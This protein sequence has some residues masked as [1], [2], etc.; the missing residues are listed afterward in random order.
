MKNILLARRYASAS[1]QFLNENDYIA[2]LKQLEI[3]KKAIAD[4]LQIK[5]I[6]AS[7]IISKN[8]KI[9]FAQNIVE[10]LDNK[11]FWLQIITVLINKNRGNILDLFLEEFKKVLNEKLNQKYVQLILAHKQDNNTIELI[12]NEL[13]KVLKFKVVCDVEIDKK[14]IGGFI[15]KT[16]NQLIDASVHSNLQRFVKTMSKSYN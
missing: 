1:I 16:D 10:Q 3:F 6:F 11:D 12:K 7:A 5:K 9:Q 8:K 2:I 4:N 15:A 13:E 14:I